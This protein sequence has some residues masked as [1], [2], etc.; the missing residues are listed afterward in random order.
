VAL[1]FDAGYNQTTGNDNIYFNNTGFAGE[2]QTLRLGS[3]GTSG[4]LGSGILTAYIAG[5][6]G[7]QVIGSAVYV[8]S[9]GQLGV[10]ASSERFKT[11]VETMHA[12]S[13]KL[14][15]LRPVT[16]KLKTD[17][18]GTIQYGLI[19]EEVARVYPELVIHGADGRIDG[20]RYE[21]LAPMLISEMQQQQRMSTAQAEKINTQAEEIRELK[22]HEAQF[23]AQE[24]RL[25]DMQ[26]QVT[27][28]RAA[29]VKLQAKDSPP[30]AETQSR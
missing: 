20:V 30:G 10:L 6:A 23:A 15:Q 24:D 18:G 4:V 9:S 3:Q 29:L 22:Q 2:S 12:A 26:N 13:E 8:T 17:P 19:A 28:M 27:E 1:G 25:R 11:D 7:S 5:V 21:E 14:A 16:F